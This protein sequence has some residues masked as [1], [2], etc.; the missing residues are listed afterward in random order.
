LL[1]LEFFQKSCGLLIK[2]SLQHAGMA[3]IA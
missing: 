2:L 1:P 3:E